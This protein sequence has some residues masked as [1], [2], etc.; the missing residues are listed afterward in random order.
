MHQ[1]SSPP[2]LLGVGGGLSITIITKIRTISISI[3][4]I[5]F[6]PLIV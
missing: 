5:H 4:V 6:N 3:T 1:P 2:L